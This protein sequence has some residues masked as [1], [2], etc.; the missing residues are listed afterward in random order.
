[1]KKFGSKL[2]EKFEDKKIVGKTASK[3]NGGRNTGNA[4]CTQGG[5]DCGDMLDASDLTKDSVLTG[6]GDGC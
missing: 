3:I 6:G 1:M 2:F 5:T 4:D